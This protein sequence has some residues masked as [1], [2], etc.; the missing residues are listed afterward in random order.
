MSHSLLR[1][2][3]LCLFLGALFASAAAQAPAPATGMAAKPSPNGAA[4]KAAPEGFVTGNLFGLDEMQRQLREQREQIE[5]MRDVLK[6]QTRLIDELR[7][8]ME[9]AERTQE[10]SGAAP[11]FMTEAAYA[12]N[13]PAAARQEGTQLDARLASVTEQSKKTSEALAKQLG[14]MTFGGDLR[15]RYESLYNQQNGLATSGDNAAAGALGN[16]LTSRQRF[17]LRARFGVRGEIGKEFEWGLRLAT[18]SFSDVNSTNQTLTDFFSRKNFALDQAYL[19]Y[20][21]SALPGLRVQAGKFEAPWARTEMTWD[22]DINVEGLSESYTRTFE[23]ALLKEVAFV[24]WQSPF[25]E[26]NAAFVLG[27]DG[28]VNLDESARAGRDLA[29][30]G[31]QA[32]VRLA[33]SKHT[34]LTLSAADLYFSGTQFINPAQFLGANV[35]FPVTVNIPASGT[36]PARTVTA[37]VSVPR[38]LL[39]AGNSNLGFSTATTNALNRDGRLASGYNLVDLIARLD[40]ARSKRWPLMLLLNFV[41]NTQAHDVITAGPGG[42][43]IVLHNG[44][45]HGYWAEFQVGRDVLRL[46]T[47]EVTRG[48][49]V[50]NYTYM[51][52]E[53]DAVLTPFNLSDL[54]QNSDV[55]AHRF[56]AAYA[57]DSRVVLSLTGIFSERPN[58]LLGPFGTT[59][60]GSLNRRLT[61]LQLDTIL[62]F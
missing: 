3:F 37:Q 60:A 25:L 7:S 19:A 49:V 33:P 20:K 32:R 6:E 51:S 21:P 35:Q 42:S 16:P 41:D 44:E 40:I 12:N 38:E 53:K 45:N 55:R 9:R 15:F 50:F 31:A 13:S 10:N 11:A 17:R 34:S 2:V 58:G 46:P 24:A 1:F 8:R 26:R 57:A 22:N 54:I 52:I 39:V 48:D 30:Y 62:R 36:T 14:S 47:K 23:R 18:G 27:A 5:Q 4:T 59:P 28:A 56:I 61:R 43:D 29:L